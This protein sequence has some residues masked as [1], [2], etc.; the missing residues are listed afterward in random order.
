MG[1]HIVHSLLQRICE[2]LDNV[3]VFVNIASFCA[4]SGVGNVAAVLAQGGHY[5]A[6]PFGFKSC[7]ARFELNGV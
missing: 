6:F 7:R 1:L 2:A 4:E 5:I 3:R